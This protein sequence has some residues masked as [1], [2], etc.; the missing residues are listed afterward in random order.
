MLK[1]E[2]YFVSLA[3]F[4]ATLGKSFKYASTHQN[5]KSHNHSRKCYLKKKAE[6]SYLNSFSFHSD[7]KL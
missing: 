6:D 5:Q 4:S 2:D 7:H 1:N 3:S